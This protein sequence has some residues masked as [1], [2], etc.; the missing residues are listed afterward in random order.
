MNRQCGRE[1]FASLRELFLEI[2]DGKPIP[3][4]NYTFIVAPENTASKVTY[5]DLTLQVRPGKCRSV[6]SGSHLFRNLPIYE[7]GGKNVR[8]LHDAYATLFKNTIGLK[9]SKLL[10]NY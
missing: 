6:R 8:T 2:K 5:I 9:N 1:K 4:Y 10:S 3:K 7:R